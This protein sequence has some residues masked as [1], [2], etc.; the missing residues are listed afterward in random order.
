MTN[1]AAA[2]GLERQGTF[3]AEIEVTLMRRIVR[4]IAAAIAVLLGAMPGFCLG[5]AYTVTDLGTLG[6]SQSHP[7][8]ISPN[9]QV[10]GEAN[11]AG[12][13]STRAV[14]FTGGIQDLGTLPGGQNSNAFGI[15]GSGQIVG[16]SSVPAGGVH[17]FLFAGGVMQDLNGLIDPSSGWLLGSAEAINDA[18]QI[19]GYGIINGAQQF[20]A[21]LLTPVL[22]PEPDSFAL[23]VLSCAG[24]VIWGWRRRRVQEAPNL[25]A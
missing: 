5:A 1:Y 20:H 21:F 25:R 3:G 11:T 17:A 4:G 23:A 15:S 7:H 8:G 13:A 10:V 14:Q 16:S 19:T 9:G 18:G 2:G 24:L 6:G 22:V 12:D